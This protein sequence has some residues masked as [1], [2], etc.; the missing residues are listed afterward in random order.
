MI[1][2]IRRSNRIGLGWCE[3]RNF[4]PVDKTIVT[5]KSGEKARLGNRDVRL[6]L[7]LD[8]RKTATIGCRRQGWKEG[9]VIAEYE[10]RFT[11]KREVAVFERDEAVAF[12]KS[13]MEH[14]KIDERWRHDNKHFVYYIFE[15]LQKEGKISNRAW[16]TFQKEVEIG[17]FLTSQGFVMSAVLYVIIKA[18]GAATGA[19][20]GALVGS[21]AG[22]AGVLIGGAIGG[23]GGWLGVSKLFEK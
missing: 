11:F 18:A 16:R 2:K 9:I 10:W 14:Q 13:C 4:V 21:F 17:L 23:L 6:V 15:R 7:L 12:V 8:G 22:P 5:L 1:E 3:D 20:A 19:S